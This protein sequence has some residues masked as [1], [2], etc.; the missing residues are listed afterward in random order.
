MYIMC[1]LYIYCVYQV[2]RQKPPYIYY[3]YFQKPP[4]LYYVYFVCGA[5][6]APVQDQFVQVDYDPFIKSQLA[7]RN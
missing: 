1:N 3:V 6:G 2:R 7:S 5:D 4:Y